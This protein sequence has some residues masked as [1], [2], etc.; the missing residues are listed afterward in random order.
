MTLHLTK[1]NIFFKF[2]LVHVGLDY[3]CTW[4][5]TQLLIL[6]CCQTRYS[7]FS[8]Q[9]HSSLRLFFQTDEEF[10][11][12][13]GCIIWHSRFVLKLEKGSSA[14]VKNPSFCW[15]FNCSCIKGVNEMLGNF[16]VLVRKCE[17]VTYFNFTGPC[18]YIFGK[19]LWSLG[20]WFRTTGWWINSFKH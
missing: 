12:S 15:T 11:T 18:I 16:T 9:S 20:Q 17:K 4:K 2:T 6:R 10:E 14:S 19:H 1:Q 3:T 13:D 5:I 8:I 7:R